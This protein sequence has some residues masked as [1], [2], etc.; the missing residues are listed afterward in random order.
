MLLAVELVAALLLGFVLGRI[1]E[2]RQCMMRTKHA[3]DRPPQVE[4]NVAVQVSK[5]PPKDED[6]LV[7]AFDRE[8]KKLVR[9]ARAAP[10]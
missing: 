3:D 5:R 2:I 7:A 4:N 6:E 10:R 9:L 8:M 1:W